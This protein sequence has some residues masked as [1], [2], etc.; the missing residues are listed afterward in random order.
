MVLINDC[1]TNKRWGEVTSVKHS[2]I[3]D[4]SDLTFP[5][6]LNPKLLFR[7]MSNTQEVPS[8]Y[9]VPQMM[10]VVNH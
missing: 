3:V 2:K 10:P 1:C 7:Q 8:V 6:S 4:G 9:I 5:R